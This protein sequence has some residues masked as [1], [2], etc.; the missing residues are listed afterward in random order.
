LLS[1]ALSLLTATVKSKMRSFTSPLAFLLLAL[2]LSNLPWSSA[3]SVCT[4]EISCS[5]VNGRSTIPSALGV[6]KRQGLTNA[7]RLRKRLPLL[8]PSRVGTCFLCHQAMVDI[9]TN[10]KLDIIMILPTRP[11]P[12]RSHTRV[13]FRFSQ[14]VL[15]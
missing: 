5:D 13:S 15:R 12:P 6:R 2:G 4:S 8:P 7:E 10:L 11:R 14:M 9:L 3:A 1:A